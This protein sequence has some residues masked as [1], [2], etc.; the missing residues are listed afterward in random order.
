[1]RTE[2]RQTVP[3]SVARMRLEISWLLMLCTRLT[4][5]T[6]QTQDYQYWWL[7]LQSPFGGRNYNLEE[8]QRGEHI[9][10]SSRFSRGVGE[11][12][13]GRGG[14]QRKITKRQSEAATLSDESLSEIKLNEI[15]TE[16]P[17][18]SSCVPR[19]F[20]ERFRGESKFDQ[21]PCLLSIGQF[22][23]EFGI[24]CQSEY[25]RKCPI[26]AVAP[27]A[28]Q[29]VPRPLGLP[30]DDECS[31]PGERDNCPGDNTLCCFNG[32]LNIC[33]EDSPYSIQKSFF[34]REKAFIVNPEGEP[35]AV[36]PDISESVFGEE[37]DD[38]FDEDEADYT[39]FINPRR[40]PRLFRND[41]ISSVK[42][43][44]NNSSPSLRLAHL[45]QRLLHRLR[46]RIS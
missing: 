13:G 23:G 14:S 33:L 24:C 19:F 28:Q 26:V 16:C 4:V 39:D 10:N 46:G 43:A 8:I 9:S 25:P 37:N 2:E 5:L 40:T 27:P 41:Q 11:G 34:I 31:Q 35:T 20:C 44:N 6:Q 29:C 21:I 12:D 42:E 32:C 22:S 30:E 38:E 45:L 1:V 18:L 17:R 15:Q 3:V 7:G 36:E